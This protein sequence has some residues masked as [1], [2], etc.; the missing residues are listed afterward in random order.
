MYNQRP[1]DA[2]IKSQL[3]FLLLS[4]SCSLCRCARVCSGQILVLALL[5]V[6]QNHRYQLS[7]LYGKIPHM[8]T[9]HF[10]N[11]KSI[12]PLRSACRRGCSLRD[13]RTTRAACQMSE[14]SPA[15]IRKSDHTRASEANSVHCS[16]NTVRECRTRVG[17]E[18]EAAYHS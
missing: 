7:T 17:A 5:A 2:P 18:R 3:K 6:L 4:L 16:S 8:L 9:F 14:V 10:A 13:R 12:S 15:P 1:R 11:F